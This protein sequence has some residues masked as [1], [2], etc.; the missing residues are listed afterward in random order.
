MKKLLITI[1]AA[2]SISC[3]GAMAQR[4]LSLEECREMAVQSDK[5]LEQ[6]K[7]SLEMAGYDRKI[8]RANYLP[9]VS[10]TGAYL[11]NPNDISIISDAT[12]ATLTNMGTTIHGMSQQ[13]QQQVMSDLTAYIQKLAATDP[14]GAMRYM[15]LMQDP[16]LQALIGKLQATDLSAVINAIGQDIDD[17][18]HPD[19]ENI[20]VGAVTVQQP[21]VMGG[22][23][24]AAYKIAKLAEQLAEA[25]YDQRYQQAIVEVDQAYWQI[26][27][28]AAKKDLAEA[29][30][31]L[32]HNMERDAEIAVREGVSTESDALQIK[33]KA[34]EA[35]MLKTKSENGLTLAKMLLCKRIG[36]PLDSGIALADEGLERIPAARIGSGKSMEEIFED[37]PETR[38]LELASR[39]YDGKVA[40]A[41]A[42]MLPKV[43]AMGGYMVS[44]PSLKNGFEKQWNGYWGVGV[45]VNVPIFHGFEALN[46]TRKAKAEATLYRSRLEDA[47]ELIN[48]QVT[49]LRKQEIEAVEKLGMA[50]SN[51]SS[52][53][54]NLRT[55]TIGFNEGVITA[56]TAMAAQTAW[57]QAHSEYI[58]AGIELQ[59]LASNIDKA[60][61]N[62][63]G[64]P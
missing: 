5:E 58:D 61:G 4:L 9:N 17:A 31:E 49:Q 28:I 36:L 13:Y 47:K 62:H 16:L 22:K 45:V 11:Y 64:I 23:I 32:L 19:L 18:L 42:D 20:L 10:A 48:L 59:M 56:N 24:V 39:I 44:N 54:E 1:L 25:R 50:E 60:E 57:L 21:I 30:A 38:S 37:R 7:T 51:L 14:A 29:Y 2:T 12:S 34:N 3:V 8:A 27:S 41:R 26:V 52:A 43:A 53:E 63:R 33:V 15:Q 40:V 6:A 35:D 46:K 55:A